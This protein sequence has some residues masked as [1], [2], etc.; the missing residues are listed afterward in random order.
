MTWDYAR[1]H[2]ILEGIV[3]DF[4][5][6]PYGSLGSNKITK[7]KFRLMRGEADI[8]SKQMQN[9][10]YLFSILKPNLGSAWFFWLVAC[11]SLRCW[12][13]KLCSAWIK[14][15][16]KQNLIDLTVRVPIKIWILAENRHRLVLSRAW[17][18]NE[19][20]LCY[21]F[22]PFIYKTFQNIQWYL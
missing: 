19:A 15:G 17:R 10:F 14:S 21:C 16:M 9:I 22:S 11:C 4:I 2:L 1:T 7:K 8:G 3:R 6:S 18:D 12:S 13:L 20:N 5:W